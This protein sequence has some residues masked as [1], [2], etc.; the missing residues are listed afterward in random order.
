MR[1]GQWVPDSLTQNYKHADPLLK[2]TALVRPYC[3]HLYSYSFTFWGGFSITH[4]SMVVCKS[5]GDTGRETSWES[6]II[7]KDWSQKQTETTM[8]Q[9]QQTFPVLLYFIWYKHMIFDCLSVI[10]FCLCIHVG[11]SPPPPTPPNLSVHTS[12]SNICV[13]CDFCFTVSASELTFKM[14]V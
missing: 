7:A 6:R 5:L 10:L 9:Q 12:T 3:E 1:S 8:Q 2:A 13:F 4:S 14:Q 11:R